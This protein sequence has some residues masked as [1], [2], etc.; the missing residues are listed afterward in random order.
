MSV[1]AE[2]LELA[3]EVQ[4]CDVRLGLLLDGIGRDNPVRLELQHRRTIAA[5]RLAELEA[6]FGW[7][8][9][10]ESHSRLS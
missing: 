2:M 1:N 4:A 8:P 9:G 10:D 3:R 5:T 7:E 6:R